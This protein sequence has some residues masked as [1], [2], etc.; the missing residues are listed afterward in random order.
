M[1]LQELGVFID[2][3]FREPGDS[4]FRME[5]LPQYAVDSDGDDYQRW[6][7]GEPEPTWARKQPWLDTISKWRDSRMTYRRVRILSERPTDY[8]RYAA[9]FGY[10]YNASAGEDIRVLHRGE[11][12]LPDGLV[13]RDF[14]VINDALVV[15]MH[16]DEHGR[17]ADAEVADA[18]ATATHIHARN[19]A[20]DAAEPFAAWWARHPEIHRQIAA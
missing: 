8:E 14:W 20:W 10:A 13:E 12:A 15:F 7:D 16:Y 17:Y 4:L 9:E 6:L 3:H 1:D 2:E 19:I 11:H 5:T 18:R